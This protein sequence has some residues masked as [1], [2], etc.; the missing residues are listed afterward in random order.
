MDKEGVAA[1]LIAMAVVGGGI[2]YAYD[3][4]AFREV[5]RPDNGHKDAV[6]LAGLAILFIVL[7]V[8]LAVMDGRSRARFRAEERRLRDERPGAT[9][10]E[11]AGPEGEGLLFEDAA[12]RV[13]LLRGPGGF[14]APRVVEIPAEP[15]PSEEPQPSFA[16]THAP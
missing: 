10:R 9:V 12:G 1:L 16:P 11:H 8:P 13:L 14:G 15:P 7:A 2:F 6:W 5:D 3:R 4:G